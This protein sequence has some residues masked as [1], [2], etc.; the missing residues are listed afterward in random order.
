MALSDIL[1]RYNVIVDIICFHF[2]WERNLFAWVLVQ[3]GWAFAG[4]TISHSSELN[5]LIG[6]AAVNNIL[7]NLKQ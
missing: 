7:V 3:S 4:P 2:F 1:K 6:T 5:S